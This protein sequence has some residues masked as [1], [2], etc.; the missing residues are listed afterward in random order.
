MPDLYDRF[1]RLPVRGAHAFGVIEREGQRLFLIDVLARFERIDK[2]FAMEVLRGSDDDRVDGLVVEQ[3]AMVAIGGRGC[4]TRL[5][6]SSR[7]L[8]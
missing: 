3:P 8:V 6:A 4:D 1:R 2:M 7:R 5:R